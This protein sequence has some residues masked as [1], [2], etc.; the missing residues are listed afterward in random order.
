MLPTML[1]LP[2]SEPEEVKIEEYCY[3]KVCTVYNDVMNSTTIY[4]KIIGWHALIFFVIRKSQ[5]QLIA[6]G[7]C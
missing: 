3:S 2:V 4:G 7:A 6:D 5:S 1:E